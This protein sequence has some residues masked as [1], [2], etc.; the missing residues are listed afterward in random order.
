MSSFNF[1]DP[2]LVQGGRKFQ[3][4]A[5]FIEEKPGEFGLTATLWDP[6]MGRKAWASS[7][8]LHSRIAALGEMEEAKK[9]Y[10]ERGAHSSSG[11]GSS[12]GQTNTPKKSV[13]EEMRSSLEWASTLKDR[14]TGRPLST[15]KIM[16]F[17][18]KGL[19]TRKVDLRPEWTQELW[20]KV[21]E[22][23]RSKRS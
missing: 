8:F 14:F 2:V 12:G 10:N 1:F 11:S 3:G 15:D 5:Y 18:R 4:P 6:I 21:R 19:H 9:E 7:K 23:W 17:A 16:E 13:E 22:E 20:D